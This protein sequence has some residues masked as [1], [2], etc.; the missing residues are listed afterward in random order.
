MC[1]LVRAARDRAG[2]VVADIL[3]SPGEIGD[4]VKRNAEGA[5]LPDQRKFLE[6]QSKLTVFKRS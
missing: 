5:A 6:T 1:D 3:T 2:D 4:V